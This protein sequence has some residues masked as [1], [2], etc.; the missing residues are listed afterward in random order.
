M[1]PRQ[2]ISILLLSPFYL[3]LPPTARLA[4]VREFCANFAS[5]ESNS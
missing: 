4:L 5:S 3:R 2:A 1:N